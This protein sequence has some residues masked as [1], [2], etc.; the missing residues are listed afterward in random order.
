VR[1]IQLDQE[2]WAKATATLRK[3][4]FFW[5]PKPVPHHEESL[6]TLLARRDQVRSGRTAAGAEARPELFHPQQSPAPADYA[7]GESRPTPPAA[8]PTPAPQTTEEQPATTTSRL[9]EAKKR[10][11]K[12]R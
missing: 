8:P 5:H 11:Q 6:A 1:R 7:T 10:A 4:V 2:E 9:L 3:W 12:R